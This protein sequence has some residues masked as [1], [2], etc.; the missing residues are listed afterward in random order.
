MLKVGLTG[1]IACGKTNVLKEFDRLGVC[2]VDAD[3]VSRDI[4]Q[5]GGS[6]YGPVVE[7][8]GQKILSAD[9]SIDRGKIGQIV[10]ANPKKRLR[11]EAIV[12]PLILKEQERILAAL[13]D[14]LGSRLT[15]IA[16]VDAALMVETG[17]YQ[18]YDL[19]VVVYCNPEIQL[20]RLMTRDHLSEEEA[21]SR[22]DS[23]MDPFEKVRYGDFVID[24]SGRFSDT[25]LQIQDTFHEL[26]SR[27]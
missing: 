16:M 17:S 1:G 12:H 18:R 4:M 2:G 7:L 10:F 11:L 19:I 23:Q 9:N 21:Q 8:F 3:Q 6:A 26:V 25:K 22:L 13:E 20:G 14:E 24:N 27:L 15:R 5:P